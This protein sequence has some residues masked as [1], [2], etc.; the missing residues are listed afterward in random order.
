MECG[1]CSFLMFKQFAFMCANAA[2]LLQVIKNAENRIA[3]GRS[4]GPGNV[5]IDHITSCD[6]F[7]LQ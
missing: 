5:G 7:F 1:E 3:R 4:C 6:C 2:V